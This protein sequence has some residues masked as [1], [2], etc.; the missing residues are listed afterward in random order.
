MSSCVWWSALC[1][2]QSWLSD[3][4]RD[5]EM[6]S[7]QGWIFSN[8]IPERGDVCSYSKSSEHLLALLWTTAV[9]WPCALMRRGIEHTCSPSQ[10][11]KGLWPSESFT[12]QEYSSSAKEVYG[13]L[14]QLFHTVYS[15]SS[16]LTCKCIF[17]HENSCL[18]IIHYQMLMY[19]TWNVENVCSSSR[20]RNF[21]SPSRLIQQYQLKTKCTHKRFDLGGYFGVK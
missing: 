13:L 10:I 11:I 18:F 5:T 8:I 19:T 14:T 6:L 2:Q 17:V 4:K 7:H 12:P 9:A 3:W 20:S 1:L 21:N 15:S 16:M